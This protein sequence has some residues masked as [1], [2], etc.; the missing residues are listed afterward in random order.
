M[1]IEDWIDFDD[2]E[3]T[4]EEDVYIEY[5]SIARETEKAILFATEQGKLWLPKSVITLHE[6]YKLIQVG[7][8]VTLNY[9]V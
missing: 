4:M 8:W 1:A 6:K 5:T 7:P 2:D 9:I 3:N